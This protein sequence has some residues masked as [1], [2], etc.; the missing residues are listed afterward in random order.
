MA[1]WGG[2]SPFQKGGPEGMCQLE[3]HYT[4]PLSSLPGKVY[5]TVL[6]RRFRMIVEPQI[7]EEQ[8]GFRPGRETADQLFT[9]AGILEEAWE[10]AHPV[11]TCCGF[12]NSI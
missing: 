9:L 8:C 5:S 3:G 11:Y 7:E 2:G 12:G 10:Y 4:T 1:D 6:E